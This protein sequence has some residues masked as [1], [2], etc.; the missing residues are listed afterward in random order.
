MD[1]RILAV[2]IAAMAGTAYAQSSPSGSGYATSSSGNA[3]RDSAGAPVS[4]SSPSTATNAT[5]AH[6]RDGPAGPCEHPRASPLHDVLAEQ[7]E[8]AVA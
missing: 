2:L 6:A 3:V 7:A 8:G 1:K 4:T 5:P